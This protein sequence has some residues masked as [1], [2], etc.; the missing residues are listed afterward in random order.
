M[1]NSCHC[2]V[3]GILSSSKTYAEEEL[4]SVSYSDREPAD[5]IKATNYSRIN[6]INKLKNKSENFSHGT[7]T[8]STKS[9][10]ETMKR[11]RKSISERIFQTE[12]VERFFRKSFN[13]NKEERLLGTYKCSLFTTAGPIKG[14]VFI[15][16][17]RITF[18]SK[19]FL[20]LSNVKGEVAKFPY[21][22][23][24]PLGKIKKTA[25]SAN[26]NKPDEKFV[27]I[28][29]VDDF[30]FWFMNFGNCQRPLVSLHLAISE[31]Q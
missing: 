19:K 29:T 12:S 14:R 6:W 1:K 9:V 10:S 7:V 17:E 27:Q 8:L 21:K 13:V 3:I 20:K 16:S 30:E 5:S 22:V 23:S 28:V 4:P 15:T 25:I 2:Q 26:L 24:V 18:H 11:N 31:Q